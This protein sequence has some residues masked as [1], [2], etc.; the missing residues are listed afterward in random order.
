MKAWS[1]GRNFGLKSGGTNSEGERGALGSQSERGEWECWLISRERN[2]LG[3]PTFGGRLSTPRAIMRPRFKVKGHMSRSLGRLMLKPEVR[4]IFRMGRPT[5]KLRTQTEHED[6]HQRQAPWPRRKVTHDASDSYLIHAGG[7]IPC[8]SHPPATQLVF[9][10]LSVQRYWYGASSS[11]SGDILLNTII[12]FIIYTVF[13][14]KHP[15]MFSIITPTFLVDFYTFLYQWK[16]EW[17]L[18]NIVI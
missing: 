18:C 3:R 14:K 12:G 8:R 9:D 17:I 11:L 10:I 7:G 5:N 6:T 2:V 15:L 13:R 4:H 1:Q 16:Q